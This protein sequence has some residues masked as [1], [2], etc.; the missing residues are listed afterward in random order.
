MHSS[1]FLLYYINI[2][3]KLFQMNYL[4]KILIN[5]ILLFTIIFIMYNKKK[6]KLDSYFLLIFNYICCNYLKIN[7]IL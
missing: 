5:L 4:I 3:I 1:L 7:P 6:K 2:F